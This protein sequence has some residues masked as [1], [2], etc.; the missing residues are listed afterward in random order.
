M[1]GPK[2]NLYENEEFQR[3]TGGALRPGGLELTGELLEAAAL[4]KGANLLDVGCGLGE[5]VAYLAERGFAAAGAEPSPQLLKKA[6]QKYPNLELRQA[7]AEAL[8]WPDSRFDAALCE[9]SFSLFKSPPRAL[10]ELHRVLQSGGRLLMSDFY[11]REGPETA[12]EALPQGSCLRGAKSPEALRALLQ[13]GGFAPLLWR[14]AAPYLRGFTARMVWEYGSAE[15][16]WRQMLPAACPAGG[17]L[18]KPPKP[19]KL[20]YAYSIWKKV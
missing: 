20:G 1:S 2:K 11:L 6:L 5:T 10:A 9:C 15:G 13:N 3:F 4:P 8:P 7:V 17:G 14:D 16:F 19:P 18:G 12:G